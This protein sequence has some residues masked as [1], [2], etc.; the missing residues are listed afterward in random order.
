MNNFFFA[1]KV[2]ATFEEF[3]DFITLVKGDVDIDNK[4]WIPIAE[5]CN[6]CTAK[7]DLIMDTETLSDDIR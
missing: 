4:H 2:F 7:Y 5:Y 6:P 1:E 3:I